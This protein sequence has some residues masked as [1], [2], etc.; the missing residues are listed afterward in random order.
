MISILHDVKDPKLWELWYI[1]SS[2]VRER[3]REIYIYI[4]ISFKDPKL[5]ELWYIPSSGV[6]QDIYHQPY[7]IGLSIKVSAR[8]LL[9]D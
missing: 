6:M 7:D 2:G 9:L 5:W 3:E 8:H 4:Y 1:P